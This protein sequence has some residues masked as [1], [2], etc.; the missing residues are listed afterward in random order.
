MPHRFSTVRCEDCG[1]K[2]NIS[3][4]CD[5]CGGEGG[6]PDFSPKTKE[7]FFIILN[8]SI[9][10]TLEPEQIDDL[11][12]EVATRLARSMILDIHNDPQYSMEAC[13]NS[14]EGYNS[15]IA[16]TARDIFENMWTSFLDW[17]IPQELEESY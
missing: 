6:H 7:H 10:D 11:A 4:D 14:L 12:E 9:P 1:E 16:S 5:D 3:N 8:E 13:L 15:H 2:F 17:E